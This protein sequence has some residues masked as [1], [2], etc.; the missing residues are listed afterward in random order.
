LEQGLAMP[1]IGK[2]SRTHQDSR[3]AFVTL[4]RDRFRY[5]SGYQ[6]LTSAS[7]DGLYKFGARYYDARGHFTQPDSMPGSISDPKTLTSF[8]YAG[9]DPI[10]SSDPSGLSLCSTNTGYW[11]PNGCIPG[12]PAGIKY[13][14]P[15]GT[16]YVSRQ[17]GEACRA[18]VLN[19]AITPYTATTGYTPKAIVG[20][21]FFETAKA[22]WK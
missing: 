3:H 15:A 14:S 13:Y 17:Q 9:G 10:N 21:L 18:T 11:V 6:D 4:F 7:D 8:N 22:C 12:A 5:I 19:L 16:E 1:Q 20:G 2:G